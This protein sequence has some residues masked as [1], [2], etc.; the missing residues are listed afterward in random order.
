[1]CACTNLL[2][3]FGTSHSAN[4][5]NRTARTRTSKQS[6]YAIRAYP[7]MKPPHSHCSTQTYTVPSEAGGKASVNIVRC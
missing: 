2:D 1:M 6:P 7:G 4:V 5:R 3:L